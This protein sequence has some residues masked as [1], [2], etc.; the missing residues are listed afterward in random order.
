MFKTN[1]GVKIKALSSNIMNNFFLDRRRHHSGDSLASQS[2]TSTQLSVS[3]Q[4]ISS[5]QKP[6]F[7]EHTNAQSPAQI[8]SS[9]QQLAQN[10]TTNQTSARTVSQPSAAQAPL[11]NH[12]PTVVESVSVHSTDTPPSRPSSA[13]KSSSNIHIS[14][15]DNQLTS[16]MASPGASSRKGR[17][18]R[19]STTSNDSRQSTDSTYGQYKCLWEGCGSGFS[20][21][22]LLRKHV[23]QQHT[24][25][26]A[27]CVWAGCDRVERKRWALVSHVTVG[28]FPRVPVGGL[29]RVTV[30]GLNHVTVGGLTHVTVGG[31]IM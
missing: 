27:A 26:A 3:Q 17:K 25:R 31:F 20:T 15:P 16:P 21:C 5:D 22:S 19:R 14:I 29:M 30:G 4:S 2:S 1:R 23:S 10:A 8:P 24:T 18:R 12:I 13:N 11:A 9:N 7:S 28:S 6:D